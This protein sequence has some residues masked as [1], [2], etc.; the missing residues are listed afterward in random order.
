MEIFRVWTNKLNY[1]LGYNHCFE[2]PE[3]TLIVSEP[4]NLYFS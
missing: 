2:D 3:I 1:K 4:L